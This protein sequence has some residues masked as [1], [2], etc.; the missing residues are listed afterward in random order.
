MPYL[1]VHSLLG[2]WQPS[3]QRLRH[4][5]AT[6]IGAVGRT[7]KKQ[8]LTMSALMDFAER[9]VHTEAEAKEQLQASY[10]RFLA[11][12]QSFSQE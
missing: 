10:S 4:N 2:K 3:A 6:L 8:H 5:P 1:L 9:G 11:E 7:A 12:N